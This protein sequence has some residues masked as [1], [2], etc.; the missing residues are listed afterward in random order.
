MSAW[1]PGEGNISDFAH[2]SPLSFAAPLAV[3][4]GLG[5]WI[6]PG[7]VHN[8]A[9]TLLV[10]LGVVAGL[11][12]GG[13]LGL[14]YTLAALVCFEVAF[15]DV[16]ALGAWA[17]PM[18][19]QRQFVRVFAA[20]LL[21]HAFLPVSRRTPHGITPV[22]LYL[23]LVLTIPLTVVSAL[24]T[25]ASPAR[26]G[27]P[28]IQL[29]LLV[30]GAYYI[31]VLAIVLVQRAYEPPVEKSES[32]RAADLERSG[33][34]A[35]ASRM[36]ARAGRAAQG[37]DTAERGG[38]L[39]LA[40]RLYAESGDAMKAGD[41]YYRVGRL[42]DAAEAYAKAGAHAAVARVYEQLARP[43][44]AAAAWERAGDVGAA[45]RAM[46]AAGRS[47]GAEMLYR[48][49][50]VGDAVTAWQ[51]EGS[52]ARAA[53]VLEHEVRDL[54]G[55]VRCYLK[56]GQS[57]H[58]GQLLERL[59]RVDEA[60]DAFA[61]APDGHFQALRLCLDARHAER[62]E[63]IL[64]AIPAATID[65][66]QDESELLTLARLH[67][68]AG[69]RRAAIGLLQK[70]RRLESSSG[71]T[72]LLLGH[73]LLDE[74]LGEL[75]EQELRIATEM[76]MDVAQQMEAAYLLGCVLE[77]Q[78]RQGEACAIFA[79]LA[80]KDLSYRDVDERYRRLRT[81]PALARAE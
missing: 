59:G 50:R 58:A 9:G 44:E 43:R 74:G 66:L 12:V 72:R 62:A 70:A 11:V 1:Q 25:I 47:P 49:G 61:A 53:E 55:A 68:Q 46:E 57:Q 18:E 33:R 16:S 34:F 5:L 39:T 71:A 2:A 31:V 22:H 45:V 76:P 13:R 35:A 56:A 80:Q 52:D 27:I 32:E 54:P 3:L 75:A 17:L 7:A 21:V 4:V 28:G 38:D 81:T 37:A 20:P 10:A 69:R 36:H 26:E 77:V 79:D 40:A 41:M 78:G 8:T 67:R 6:P 51:A 48:A 64:A 14:L 42:E 60:I 23:P 73:L 15:R 65:S 63:A 30:F 29:A 19:L 24:R